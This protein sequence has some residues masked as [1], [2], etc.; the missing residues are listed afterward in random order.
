MANTKTT[1]IVSQSLKK[2]V[3]HYHLSYVDAATE[4]DTVVYSSSTIATALGITNPLSCRVFAV[5]CSN[6]CA[7]TARLLLEFDATT[8]T[9]LVG[10]CAGTETHMCFEDYGTL[11]N[12]GGAGKNGDIV[13]TCSG[14]GTGD[15][16]TI[17]LEVRPQ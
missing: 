17:V 4:T 14:L 15:Q 3:I 16:I 6:N 2:V 1:T 5:H 12:T 9:P 11:Q 10:L 7:A 13:L 8:D